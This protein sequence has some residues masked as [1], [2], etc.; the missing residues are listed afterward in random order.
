M[1]RQIVRQDVEVSVVLQRFDQ[2]E[3]PQQA[4]VVVDQGG[5]LFR[6]S[7]RVLHGDDG[8]FEVCQRLGECRPGSVKPTRSA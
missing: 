8:R 4:G 3:V 1:L 7:P 5:L 2:L 6:A